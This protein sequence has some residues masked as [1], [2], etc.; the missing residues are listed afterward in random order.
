MATSLKNRI[1]RLEQMQSAVF[2]RDERSEDEIRV[3]ILGLLV[4]LEAI[5]GCDNFQPVCEDNLSTDSFYAH[6]EFMVSLEPAEGINSDPLIVRTREL[7]KS[8]YN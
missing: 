6:Q 4:E 8:A 3:S 2:V 5:L 7:L 1:K